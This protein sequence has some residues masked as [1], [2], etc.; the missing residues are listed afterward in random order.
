M[1]SSNGHSAGPVRIAV[2]GLGYWGPNLVRNLHELEE[3]EV[4]YICDLDTASLDKIGR[5]YPA[6]PRTTDFAEVLARPDVD[7][8]AIATPVSTHHRLA[9]AALEAGKHV[10]VEKPLAA[11]AAEAEDLIELASRHGRM[12]M[13]GHTFLYS[14]PVTL[15]KRLIDSGELGEIYFISTSRV[16]LGLHQSDVS[17]VW[18]LGPHDFSILRY[19]LGE[20]PATVSAMSRGCVME[21]TP[22][23]AFV[24]LAFPGGAVAHVELSWL[25]PSKLRR[26]TIVGSRKMVVYDDTSN[27]PVRVFDSGADLKDP[28]T[29][30]EFRLTYRSGDIVSPA[31]DAAE[32][33]SLELRDFCEASRNGFHARSSSQ[34]GLDVVR[35]IESVDTSLAEG[36]R[37]VDVAVPADVVA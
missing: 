24:N 10:F 15:I 23:V 30:G 33:L 37:P 21:N 31:V 4:A 13:P 18:D 1:S 11:S 12:L 19:W 9:A 25:A 6:I 26:T 29:F 2:V 5:R 7:A 17:V 35:I 3:A 27:E 36:G 14:P 16:N 34:L 32:P 22:D 28:E 20:L 8:V